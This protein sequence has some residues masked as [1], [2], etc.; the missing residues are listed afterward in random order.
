MTGDQADFS[1][2]LK[3]VLPRRWFASP[4]PI[5][6][7]VVAGIAQALSFA[8]TL[9]AYAK[10]QTRILTASDG[11]LDLISADFLGANLLRLPNEGDE[12]YRARILANLFVKG[13]TRRGLNAVLKLLTGKTPAI[14]EPSNPHDTGGWDGGSFYFDAAGCWGDPLPFQSFLTVYR[15]DT[16]L[17]SLAEWDAYRF[18]WDQGA[19][20]SD[21]PP[22]AITD[23]SLI[24]A[25]ESTR[26]LGSVIWMRIASA[27][28]SP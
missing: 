10:L 16:S 17:V 15:P 18:S 3:A 11:W 4:T 21:L 8:Y 9:Y 13:P 22:N 27:P 28:V 12:P 14:V 26:A 1:Q 7:A 6:D 20:W 23:A 24:A 5:L 25:V 19:Y 2:R